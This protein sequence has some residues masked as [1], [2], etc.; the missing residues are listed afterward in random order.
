[1]LRS[2]EE[3]AEDIKNQLNLYKNKIISI[4][5]KRDL[6]EDG[7]AMKK[8]KS[9]HYQSQLTQSAS[10]S[11][12][13]PQNRLRDTPNSKS[14]NKK[15]LLDSINTAAEPERD[16]LRPRKKKHQPRGQRE[17]SDKL[18]RRDQPHDIDEEEERAERQEAKPKA[19]QT[20]QPHQLKSYKREVPADQ[21]SN[22]D[23]LQMI[24]DNN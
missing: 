17:I 3:E 15:L 4:L 11:Y 2:N 13:K 7:S 12:K 18:D 10:A 5:K 1:M 24:N 19:K 16:K 23:L 20:E 22:L 6:S 8:S 9:G 14:P 21:Q